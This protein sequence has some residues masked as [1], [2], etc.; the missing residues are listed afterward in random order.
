M[1]CAGPLKPD[2]VRKKSRLTQDNLI[3]SCFGGNLL[4]AALLIIMIRRL[5]AVERVGLTHEFPD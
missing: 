1:N 3:S 5:I 2:Y 4:S